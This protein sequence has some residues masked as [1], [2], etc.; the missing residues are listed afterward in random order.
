MKRLASV[1]AVA[2]LC[3]AFLAINACGGDQQVVMPDTGT[4]SPDGGASGKSVKVTYNGNSSTVALG[5]L[6]TVSLNGVP[7]AKLADVLAAAIPGKT[8]DQLRAT[9]FIGADG[10]TPNSKTNCATLLPVA[11]ATL[12]KGYIDPATRNL[13]WDESLTYPGCMIVKDTAEII[14]ADADAAGAD[15]SVGAPDSNAAAPDASVMQPDASATEPDAGAPGKTVKVTYTGNSTDV[16]LDELPPVAVSG[17][18]V[19]KLSDVVLIA[20]TGKAIDQLKLTGII[21]S[22]GYNPATKPSCSGNFPVDG[23]KL[24]QGYIDRSTRKILWDAALSMPGC[25]S[26]TDAA[27]LQVADK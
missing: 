20:V 2:A 6:T 1:A 22:D 16:S 19:D 9:D 17:A 12:A 14:V 26:V 13:K 27:E 3:G 4:L 25:M 10:F 15:A 24:T 5:Q 23:A 7:Y 8:L 18:S 21:A 11:G